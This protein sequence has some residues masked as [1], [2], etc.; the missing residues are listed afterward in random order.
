[1][2]ELIALKT[3]VWEIMGSIPEKLYI[4]RRQYWKIHCH[5]ILTAKYFL[6]WYPPPP[7]TLH[8]KL[9]VKQQHINSCIYE[10]GKDEKVHNMNYLYFKNR[11]ILKY[12]AEIRTCD[13]QQQL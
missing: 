8:L 13:L 10:Q 3:E 4:F 11:F 5:H 1:M 9:A 2:A 6:P 7:P 12:I